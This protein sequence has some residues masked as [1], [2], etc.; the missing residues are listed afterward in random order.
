MSYQFDLVM[1]IDDTPI[2]RYVCLG[3]IQ[4]F[5][6]AK[7]VLEF[8]M[9]KKALDY[10]KENLDKPENLPQVIF[11]DI[12]MPEMNG[13]EFLEEAAKLPPV[14]NQSCCIVMLTSS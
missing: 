11:L 13:F 3:I 4:R 14:V 10:L 2:D 7:K 9:A 12:N 6:F 1:S 8:D 5:G